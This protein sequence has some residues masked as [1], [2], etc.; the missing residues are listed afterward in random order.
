MARK[1]S[2]VDDLSRARLEQVLPRE[3][4]EAFGRQ[5]VFR[6]LEDINSLG[7]RLRYLNEDG[8]PSAEE[9]S[10]VISRLEAFVET[11]RWNALQAEPLV[12]E[13]ALAPL[14]MPED[15]FA[16]ALVLSVL[17]AETA[18]VDRW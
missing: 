5:L 12:W 7:D 1:A 17:S 8:E 6:R 15:A 14:E 4:L 2:K 11:M 13:Y 16:P 9:M 3:R 18:K 10:R